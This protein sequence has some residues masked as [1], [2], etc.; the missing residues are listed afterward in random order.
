MLDD[1]LESLNENERL[2]KAVRHFYDAYYYRISRNDIDGEKNKNKRIL[3][4]IINSSIWNS[5][6]ITISIIYQI[7]VFWEPVN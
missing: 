2:E 4:S 1:T 6:L 5:L 7:L 3:W